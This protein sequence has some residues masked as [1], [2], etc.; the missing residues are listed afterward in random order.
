MRCKIRFFFIV[1]DILGRAALFHE[2]YQKRL[3][4]WLSKWGKD[5]LFLRAASLLK[6]TYK[7]F[8]KSCEPIKCTHLN[9]RF[10]TVNSISS[11]R[12]CIW[13]IAE[14]TNN[15]NKWED[16]LSGKYHLM[17]KNIPEPC[18]YWTS[19]KY[20]KSRGADPGGFHPYSDPDMI[21]REK[22]NPGS[23]LWEKNPDPI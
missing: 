1:Y 21:L 6:R 17:K 14:S 4:S 23:D 18:V 7:V 12:V 15:S 10:E 13:V 22:V 16:I 3:H 19:V 11:R 8:L 2:W 5:M 20:L 9:V